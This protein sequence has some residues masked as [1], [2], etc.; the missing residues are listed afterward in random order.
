ME[1]LPF[2]DILPFEY[3]EDL[4]LSFQV[5]LTV[6]VIREVGGWVVRAP[7]FQTFE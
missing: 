2:A 3:S 5:T 4:H 6:W 1:G 7:T